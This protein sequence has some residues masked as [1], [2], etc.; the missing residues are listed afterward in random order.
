MDGV[1]LPLGIQALTDR[2][3]FR[4]DAAEELCRLEA[5]AQ[6]HQHGPQ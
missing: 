5:T 1:V 3:L 4:I 2:T 6:P